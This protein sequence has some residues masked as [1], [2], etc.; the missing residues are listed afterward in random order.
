MTGF[1]QKQVT[2]KMS[3]WKVDGPE[4]TMFFPCEDFTASQACE[5]YDFPRAID[6]CTIERG[7]GARIS[8]PRYLDCADWTIFDSLP[9]AQAWIDEV[10]GDDESGEVK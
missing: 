2:I 10:Y 5:A 7:H 9:E 1:M 4:G 6:S 3:W 8:S